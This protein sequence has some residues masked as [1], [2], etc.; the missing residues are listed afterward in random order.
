MYR[1]A[2]EG[3]LALELGL[4]RTRLGDV[5]VALTCLWCRACVG[6]A[7]FCGCDN[8]RSSWWCTSLL[9]ARLSSSYAAYTTALALLLRPVGDSPSAT[10]PFGLF[11]VLGR[12]NSGDVFADTDALRS[13]RAWSR[14]RT[15]WCFS[16][17]F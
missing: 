10:L 2:A 6:I 4:D 16:G 5:T 7:P 13:R 1:D 11:A 12:D 17:S 14:S 3:V 8:R 9:S 15:L